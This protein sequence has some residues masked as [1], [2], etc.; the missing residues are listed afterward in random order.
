MLLSI[1]SPLKKA[2]KLARKSFHIPRFFWYAAGI[3]IIYFVL[4]K[5]DILPS[6]KN[7]FKS[8]PV[9]ID[10]TPVLVK[11]MKNIAQLMTMSSYDEVV[12]DSSKTFATSIPG[13]SKEI[14]LE[15]KSQLVIIAKGQ[16]VAGIDLQKLD[17][18]KIFIQADSVAITLPKAEVLD[19]I[20][21]PSNYEIFIEEKGW[22]STE[23]N[24]IKV[25]ARNNMIERAM[26]QGLLKKAD[27]KAK[28]IMENFLRSAGFKKI[29]VL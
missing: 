22:Q 11:E 9:V 18:S 21:N 13:F 14:G 26:K 19:A 25:K 2:N 4:A 24:S 16:I 5:L 6:L 10:S 29:S 28:M 1:S 15:K 23:V 12:V 7:L 17:E 20:V 27:L 3:A 8:K